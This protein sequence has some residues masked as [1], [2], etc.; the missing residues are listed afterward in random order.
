MNHLSQHARRYKASGT[1]PSK[2]GPA[3]HHCILDLCGPQPVATDVDDVIHPPCDLVVAVLCPV[4]PITSEVVACT[5]AEELSTK[6]SEPG[7]GRAPIRPGGTQQDTHQG[8]AQQKKAPK[9]Q[10]CGL[11][12]CLPSCQPLRETLL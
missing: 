1:Y 9:P 5:T 3:A 7:P 2:G 12:A 8:L 10:L 11:P 4:C 6:T